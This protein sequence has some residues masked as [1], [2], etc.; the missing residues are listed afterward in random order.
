MEQKTDIYQIFERDLLNIVKRN[1]NFAN[2]DSYSD[3]TDLL[4][5]MDVKFKMIVDKVVGEW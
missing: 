3:T 2:F 5:L 1:I 4:K